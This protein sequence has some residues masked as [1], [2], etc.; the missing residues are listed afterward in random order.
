MRSIVGLVVLGGLLLLPQ[1][2]PAQPVPNLELALGL[3]VTTLEAP[4]DA[5]LRQMAAGGVVATWPL[6]DP[7]S[8]ESGLLLNQKGAVVQSGDNRTRYGVGY[9]DLPLHLRLDGPV[10][11]G[12]APYLSVGGFGGVKLFEQQRA[13]GE[14][15]FPLD[16]ERA[17]FERT[18]AGLSGSLGG[19]LPI[20]NER[21]LRLAVHYEH[22]LVNVAR[23][24][25]AS[26]DKPFPD[27]AQ[28]RTW[29]I[30]LRFGL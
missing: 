15:R 29:S 9:L 3:N 18:N 25:G 13:G 14:L 30:R 10:L 16:T 8:L 17:F 4:T 19:T 23:S 27:A 11:G 20:G 12:I 28:T 24:T 21:A 7:L 22:G 1:A 2:V 26:S 6:A 5:G